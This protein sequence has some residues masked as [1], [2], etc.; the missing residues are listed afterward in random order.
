MV[1]RGWAPRTD[2]ESGENWPMVIVGS[3]FQIFLYVHPETPKLPIFQLPLHQSTNHGAWRDFGGAPSHQKFQVPTMQ[4]LN[5]T[6]SGYFGGGFSL[7]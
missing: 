3:W 7:T 1:L 6:M 5:H 2:G 4:V